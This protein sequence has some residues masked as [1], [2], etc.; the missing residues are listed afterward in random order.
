MPPVS[1]GV[2]IMREQKIVH[3][4]QGRKQACRLEHKAHLFRPVPGKAVGTQ[5]EDIAS[6]D[7]NGP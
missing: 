6:L 4:R 5:A 7:G 1:G 2:R 3:H